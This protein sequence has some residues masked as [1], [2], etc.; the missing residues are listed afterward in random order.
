E[1]NE[2]IATHTGFQRGFQDNSSKKDDNLHHQ[3]S[4]ESSLNVLDLH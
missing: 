3:R 4:L 1:R 2:K